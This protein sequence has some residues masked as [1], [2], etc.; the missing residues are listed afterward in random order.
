MIQGVD[1]QECVAAIGK[2]N[3]NAIAVH[4]PARASCYSSE[5]VPELEI[6]NHMIGQFKKKS[7]TLV[8]LQQLLLRGLRCIKMQ[9]I[10]ECQS[11]LVSHDGKKVNF[12][13][14]IDIRDFTGKRERSD[15][16]VGFG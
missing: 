16:A 5:K 7:E 4:N 10:I 11:D 1:P 2:R 12:F 15:F 8:L 14:C 9:R 3:A 6:G 13:G